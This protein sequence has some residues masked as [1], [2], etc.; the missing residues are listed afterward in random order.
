MKRLLAPL[1]AGFKLGV[2]I[3]RAAYRRG[4]LKT[5]R[6]LRP[7]VSVG[8]LTTGGTGKTP[9]VR[10]ITGILLRRGGKPSILTRGYGRR[11]HRELIVLEPA[12]ERKPDAR[13]VGDEPAMVARSLPEV[14]I[15]VC[16]DRYRAGRVAEE[17]FD[18]DVHIL[19]DGFQHWSLAREVDIVLLDVTREL[20]DQALLPAGHQRETCTALERAHIVVLTRTELGDPG[21]LT[22]L[23]RR[24]NPKVEIFQER[25][26]LCGFVDIKTEKTYPPTALEG[27]SVHAFCGIGNPR[28]FFANLRKWG[29]TLTGVDT[30]HDHH[31]YGHGEIGPIMARAAASGAKAI[32][33]TEKDAMNFMPI[34]RGT[35]PFLACVIT[36]EILEAQ[37]FENA[38]FSRLETARGEN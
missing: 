30:F 19:D 11:D 24:I 2:A 34:E 10:Y 17:R 27:S 33:T 6:L 28:A 23:V 15:V 9:L 38:L 3:R 25:T 37:D 21:P 35:I 26:K 22:K 18:V 29:L 8:N 13:D 5:R 7:V 31:V 14:P 36:A 32:V 20:S 4:W 12:A 16:A 1:G